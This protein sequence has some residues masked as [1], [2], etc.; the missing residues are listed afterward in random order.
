[1]LTLVLVTL[2]FS[3][4]AVALLLILL[5]R[6]PE[7]SFTDRVRAEIDR[8]STIL[9]EELRLARDEGAATGR[10][11]REEMMGG[12]RILG[13]SLTVR[14]NGDAKQQ[15]DHLQTFSTALTDSSERGEQRLAEM[16]VTLDERLL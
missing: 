6:K 14:L 16:R 1:M 7:A 2:A 15:L 4:L 11:L 13:E 9:R 8:L 10:Q 3:A 5:F 12:L